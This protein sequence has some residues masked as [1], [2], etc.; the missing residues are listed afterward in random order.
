MWNSGKTLTSTSSGVNRQNSLQGPQAGGEVGVRVHDPLGPAGRA[1]AVKHQA[2]PIAADRGLGE[3]AFRGIPGLGVGQQTAQL[4]QLGSQRLDDRP[5]VVA[6]HHDPR[7]AVLEEVTQLI[8]GEPR[9]QRKRD[10]P[11]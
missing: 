11:A 5:L 9:V 6:G 1:R 7:A 10:R 2:W 8:G 3:M 4:R